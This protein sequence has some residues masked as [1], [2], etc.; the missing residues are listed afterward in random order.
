MR[1]SSGPGRPAGD[2]G[3]DIGRRVGMMTRR[4]LAWGGAASLAALAGWKWIASRAPDQ[5]IPW[6]LRRALEFDARAHRVAFGPA[7]KLAPEFAASAA[8]MPRVNGRIGLKSKLDLAAWRL[9]VSGPAG[10]NTYRLD[11]VKAL[12]RHEVTT[13][14]KCI[15][16]WSVVVRWAGARLADLA[17]ASGLATRS[18]RP[19][20]PVGSPAD[21]IPY[22]SLATPDAQ[23][24][25]GLDAPSA[26]HPQT[27]L[28]YEMDGKPLEPW[29]GAPLRL[30]VPIKYGIKSLKRIGS[31]DFAVDRPADYWAEKGYDWFSGH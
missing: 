22:V 4:G 9:Q 20:D 3:E 24:Y 13:E 1:K 25:V 19:L 11:D 10:S 28:C 29:H 18:G 21:M 17:S 7:S 2:A 31:I 6:P 23:Y 12:P 5:G 26:F 8:R 30:S 14:L 16:G 15:E 27:L